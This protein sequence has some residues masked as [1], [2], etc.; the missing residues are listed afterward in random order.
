MFSCAFEVAVGSA[1]VEVGVDGVLDMQFGK[2][3]YVARGRSGREGG[4]E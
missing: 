1:R 4:D 3:E 2:G